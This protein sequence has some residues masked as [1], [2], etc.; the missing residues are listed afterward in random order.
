VQHAPGLSRN[1]G[2]QLRMGMTEGIYRDSSQGIQVLAPVR[3]GN[4]AAF[5]MAEGHR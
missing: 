2:N 5:A 3:I 1:G 4:P